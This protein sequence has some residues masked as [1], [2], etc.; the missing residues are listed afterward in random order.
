M[1]IN[2]VFYY[3]HPNGGG[4]VAETASVDP[5]AYLSPGVWVRD[6]AQITGPAIIDE[7]IEICHHAIINDRVRILG[8]VSISGEAMISGDAFIQ[9][10]GIIITDEVVIDG[11]SKI[12]GPCV[13]RGRQFLFSARISFGYDDHDPRLPLWFSPNGSFVSTVSLRLLA[14]AKHKEE[15]L[16]KS[17][18]ALPGCS[19]PALPPAR[20]LPD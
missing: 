17:L 8:R 6:G 12:F 14:E 15:I 10:N 1:I 13:L 4:L 3:R 2:G 20:H 7:D 16:R 11:K 5:Q 9:G 18:S 19:V